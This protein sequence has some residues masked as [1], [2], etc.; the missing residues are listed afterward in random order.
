MLSMMGGGHK[1]SQRKATSSDEEFLPRVSEQSQP[2]RA[3]FTDIMQRRNHQLK[4]LAELEREKQRGAVIREAW[5]GEKAER[6]AKQR[7]DQARR[8]KQAAQTKTPLGKL[9]AMIERNRGGLR[10]IKKFDTLE[11]S[12]RSAAENHRNELEALQGSLRSELDAVVG[13]RESLARQLVDAKNAPEEIRRQME[14]RLSKLQQELRQREN[15]LQTQRIDVERELH[16]T[17]EEEREK[18]AMEHQKELTAMAAALAEK[19]S[20]MLQKQAELGRDEVQRRVQELELQ[21]SEVERQLQRQK[22]S[23][24][25]AQKA[26]MT[27]AHLAELETAKAQIA[28]R[29]LEVRAERDRLKNQLEATH[30]AQGKSDAE[31]RELESQLKSMEEQLHQNEAKLRAHHEEVNEDIEKEEAKLREHRANKRNSDNLAIDRLETMLGRRPDSVQQLVSENE[32]SRARRLGYDDA[33][34]R[35]SLHDDGDS[36]SANV[37]GISGSN[38]QNT[39]ESL[40]ALH[41]GD[42][43]SDSVADALIEDALAGLGDNTSLG[44]GDESAAPVG[45]DNLHIRTKIPGW[46]RLKNAA[47][48]KMGGLMRLQE[49]ANASRRRE[50]NKEMAKS[51]SRA[52]LVLDL[53]ELTRTRKSLEGG[54]KNS[55]DDSE[56]QVQLRNLDAKILNR[57]TQLKALQNVE[58]IE[59]GNPLMRLKNIVRNR[60]HKMAAMA[61]MSE[62]ARQVAMRPEHE[63]RAS[64]LHLKNKMIVADTTI[65]TLEKRGNDISHTLRSLH[66]LAANE[67]EEE[68]DIVKADP[69]TATVLTR[70]LEEVRRKVSQAEDDIASAGDK[71]ME[72]I[73]KARTPISVRLKN[74]R[75]P[76]R[77]LRQA[78]ANQWE[79]EKAAAETNNKQEQQRL[80]KLAQMK[81]LIASRQAQIR[82]Q[83]KEQKVRMEE[84]ER[85]G[86]VALQN[87]LMRQ[88]QVTDMQEMELNKDRKDIETRMQ[89]ETAEAHVVAAESNIRSRVAEAMVNGI[90][91]GF[92]L[93]DLEREEAEL[94]HEAALIQ[95]IPIAL[96]QRR[97]QTTTI[98]TTTAASGIQERLVDIKRKLHVIQGEKVL[99]RA[100]IHGMKKEAEEATTEFDRQLTARISKA[101]AMV[102]RLPEDINS[103]ESPQISSAHSVG[104]N[105]KMSPTLEKGLAKVQHDREQL[106]R[107]RAVSNC[108]RS[109][110]FF[111]QHQSHTH[112]PSFR[113]AHT[114]N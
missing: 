94:M 104:S 71:A 51:Q 107:K 80:G 34:S 83:R 29:E 64:L 68:E 85:A 4:L 26:A 88:K 97:A 111:F 84:A 66:S 82:S 70:E 55:D 52:A 99:V 23:D 45:S 24:L 62:M 105:D 16:A 114:Y 35:L 13:E 87:I 57:S 31:K 48:V 69:S 49:S 54:H 72:L 17:H 109:G 44:G 32:I 92:H 112:S 96:L 38:T 63:A 10:L 58:M 86:D 14:E 98:D 18:I 12:A 95:K 103:S 108:R 90:H 74:D 91:L 8:A 7:G 61:H 81:G 20:A 46:K 100:R 28:E 67:E 33:R 73:Q 11:E 39:I 76:L 75:E 65:K 15:E 22:E 79:S 77:V 42:N 47:A 40:N 37:L 106:Q 2:L 89:E 101:D 59:K 21:R 27:Q 5:K 110:A 3:N 53:A 50:A 93:D 41:H 9:K 102:Q 56:E 30:A 25:A 1:I 43:S 6:L 19:Q 36:G 113:L 60:R 78:M